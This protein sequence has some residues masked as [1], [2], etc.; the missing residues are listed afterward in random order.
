MSEGGDLKLLGRGWDLIER[1]LAQAGGADRELGRGRGSSSQWTAAPYLSLD[2]ALWEPQSCT[3]PV[4]FKEQRSQQAPGW[5]TRT[6]L[7]KFQDPQWPPFSRYLQPGPSW[8]P[9]PLTSF[10]W[11]PNHILSW[12][13]TGRSLLGVA[14]SAIFPPPL[15][16][17]A[18]WALSLPSSCSHTL[19][20]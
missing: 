4:A 14:F 19:L 13:S 5:P 3:T 2:L 15:H 9:L 12:F 11:L 20:I 10:L 17:G 7:F 1:G 6:A 16:L 18:S 8:P